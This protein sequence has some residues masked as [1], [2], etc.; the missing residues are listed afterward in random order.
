MDNIV[1]IEEQNFTMIGKNCN[2]SGNFNFEG[3]THLAGEIDGE[4]HIK[5]NSLLTFESTSSVKGKV[6]CGDLKVYGNVNG[7]I[8]S[9]G[10]VEIFPTGNISG[11][12]NAKNLVVHPGA[13]L[14]FDGHTAGI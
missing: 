13:V 11:L 9:K 6:Y 8:H 1:S 7:E 12:I 3:A 4:I 2:L 10:L 14:N 5:E